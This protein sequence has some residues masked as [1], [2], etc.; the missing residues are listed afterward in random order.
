MQNIQPPRKGFFSKF[1]KRV[2]DILISVTALVILSPI[3]LAAVVAVRLESKG[4]AFF[5]SKR[6]GE[7]YKIFNMIKFRTMYPDADKRLAEVAHLNQ[8]DKKESDMPTVDAACSHCAKLGRFCSPIMI[9]DGEMRCERSIQ[10]L[11]DAQQGSAFLKISND[12]RIT[13]V[14]HF[15]RKTSIDELPQLINVLKGDM[16][17]VGNRPIPLYEA[18]LLTKDGAVARFMAPAGLTGLWQVS[19]RGKADMSEQERIDLDNEYA[20]NHNLLL[21]TQIILKTIP[22]LLQSENV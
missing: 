9:A 15:L 20:N 3:L 4:P 6:V 11:K 8:Y 13:R 22:A 21:D 18:Q 5:V 19:K 16:S 1:T 2:L 12:P 14:G 7:G 10:A 17:I